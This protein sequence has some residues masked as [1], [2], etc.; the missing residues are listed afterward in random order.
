MGNAE[1]F[2]GRRSRLGRMVPTYRRPGSVAGSQAGSSRIRYA[3]VEPYC[4]VPPYCSVPQGPAGHHDGNTG[5]T[6]SPG[7]ADVPGG[8][9][10]VP[11]GGDIEGGPWLT[12]APVGGPHADL[13][14]LVCGGIAA[15]A[16]FAAAFV[17]SGGAASHPAAPGAAVPAV[18]SQAC[19][20]P[21]PGP[22]P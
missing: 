11:R 16:A 3:R 6:S 19:P 2:S 17:A 14:V 4:A 21:A 15:A 20:S 7:I 10:D 12:G 9:A 13:W 18:V 22:T 5:A 8:L 1:G